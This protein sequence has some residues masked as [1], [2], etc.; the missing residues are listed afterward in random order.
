MS[1]IENIKYHIGMSN[2]DNVSVPVD[3]APPFGEKDPNP[4]LATIFAS[5]STGHPRSDALVYL[6]R[7]SRP[8]V[9]DYVA[10]NLLIQ[11]DV[12]NPGY[13]DADAVLS[14]MRQWNDELG[15]METEEEYGNR[16]LK[17]ATE[18]MQSKKDV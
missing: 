1:K 2:I 4:M 3:P 15:R 5:D 6:S 8:E 10:R 14:G 7:D 9:R 16:L 12:S 17:I 18:Q 11:T 13:S